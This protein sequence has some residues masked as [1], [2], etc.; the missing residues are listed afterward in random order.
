MGIWKLNYSV[1]PIV[2]LLI[3][4]EGANTVSDYRPISSLN[5]IYKIYRIP[6]LYAKSFTGDID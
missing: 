3:K 5:V 6:N 1:R 2:V 4:K